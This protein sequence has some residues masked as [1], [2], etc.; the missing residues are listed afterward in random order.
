MEKSLVLAGR[1]ARCWGASFW[2]SRLPPTCRIRFRPPAAGWMQA[3]GHARG[4]Q[5]LKYPAPPSHAGFFFIL[6]PSS[7]CLVLAGRRARSWGATFWNTQLPPT[8]RI[9]FR[10]PAAGWLQARGHAR[11]KRRLKYPAPP[12]HAGF[13]FILLS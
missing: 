9:H 3:R 1:R 10:P 6:L 11:E 8:C 13:F 4:E 7:C 5:R 12:S 2:N